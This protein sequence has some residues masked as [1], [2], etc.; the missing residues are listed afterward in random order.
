MDKFL[1]GTDS[2]ANENP[3]VEWTNAWL[4]YLAGVLL[5][6][7]SFQVRGV[8]IDFA[9]VNFTET[10]LAGKTYQD[11]P[12]V[13]GIS[14]ILHLGLVVLQCFRTGE[15][16]TRFFFSLTLNPY[17]CFGYCLPQAKHN[18]LPPSTRRRLTPSPGTRST[19]KV[20]NT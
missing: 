18:N 20:Y 11:I 6:H 17:C 16:L 15:R 1:D 19:K 8:C 3:A 13:T 12:G 9:T 5:P 10:D 2:S 4:R 7:V 14:L